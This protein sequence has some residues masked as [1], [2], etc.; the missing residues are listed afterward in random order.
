MKRPNWKFDTLLATLFVFIVTGILGLIAIDLKILD[1]FARGFKDF[2][3]TNIYYSKI[4]KKQ[5]KIDTNICIVNC[6][7]LQRDSIALLIS[8]IN[9]Q[10]PKVIGIDLYFSGRKEPLYD[11]LLKLALN[12]LNNTVLAYIINNNGTGRKGACADPYFGKFKMGYSNFFPNN[13]G[14]TTIYS[15]KPFFKTNNGTYLSFASALIRSIDSVAYKKLLSRGNKMEDIH[16]KGSKR[17]FIYKDPKDIFHSGSD[18]EIL[19]NKVVLIGYTGKNLLDTADLKD[20]NFTP[21]NPEISGRAYP[22]MYGV[23]IHANIIS[24]MLNKDYINIA[25]LWLSWIVAFILCYFHIAFFMYMYVNYHK[26]FHF[27]GKLLQF[28]SSAL[29]ILICFLFYAY[30]NY[31]FS[32]VLAIANILLALDLLYFYEGLVLLIAKKWKIK[33]VFIKPH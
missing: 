31:K 30:A 6:A 18:L 16:Y 24:M 27:T 21:M 28:F 2:D 12:D 26:W 9:R 22:D 25:P 20:N 7:N 32:M 15:F 23:L 10:Q 14:P 17:A 5:I 29:L 13:N 1:P 4:R 11:S 3:F 33:S 8:I 19:K